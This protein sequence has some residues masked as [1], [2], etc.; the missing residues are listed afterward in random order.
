MEICILGALRE[1][2]GDRD[3]QVAKKEKGVGDI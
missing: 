3:I 1:C 2:E